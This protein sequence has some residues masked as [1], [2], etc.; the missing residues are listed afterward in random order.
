MSATFS[1]IIQQI[2]RESNSGAIPDPAR[3][4]YLCVPTDFLSGLIRFVS[5]MQVIKIGVGSEI[6]AIKNDLE[7][8]NQS[9]FI[10]KS[11][12]RLY[13]L[14]VGA[15]KHI[16]VICTAEGERAETAGERTLAET[17]A[18]CIAGCQLFLEYSESIE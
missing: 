4:G 18:W 15:I 13:K 5:M 3:S 11:D 8:A 10:S 17:Y 12:D 16:V 9:P 2:V 14:M 6:A 7:I 1:A